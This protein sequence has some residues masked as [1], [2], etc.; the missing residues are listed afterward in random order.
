[1][2]DAEITRMVEARIAELEKKI[3]DRINKITVQP[4]SPVQSVQRSGAAAISESKTVIVDGE[5][6]SVV[7]IGY[8]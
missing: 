2:N 1:M 5:A 7:F 3:L 4:A 8:N 6:G